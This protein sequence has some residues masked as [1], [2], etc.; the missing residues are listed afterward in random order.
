[1]SISQAALPVGTSWL[2]HRRGRLSLSQEGG[3]RSPVAGG[4]RT[5]EP[6]RVLGLG[7]EGNRGIP[8]TP[9]RGPLRA[10]ASPGDSDGGCRRAACLLALRGRWRGG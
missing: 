6:H 1:M 7:D 4:G 8:V 9:L 3:L 5:P 10:A 2:S